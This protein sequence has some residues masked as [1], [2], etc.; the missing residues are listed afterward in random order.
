MAVSFLTILLNGAARHRHFRTAF[1]IPLYQR[2]SGSRL[3]IHLQPNSVRSAVFGIVQSS[4]SWFGLLAYETVIMSAWGVG[5]WIHLPVREG[6]SPSYEAA[7]L[8]GAETWHF[9]YHPLA[10]FSTTYVGYRAFNI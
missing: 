2:G 8:D 4:T 10:L 5:Q 1:Y 7:E 9:L 3:W 6:H